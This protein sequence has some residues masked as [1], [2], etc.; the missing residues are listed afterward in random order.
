MPT[1]PMINPANPEQRNRTTVEMTVD[2][3]CV[4]LDRC[5]KVKEQSRQSERNDPTGGRHTQLKPTKRR[6][7][8]LRIPQLCRW[9]LAEHRQRR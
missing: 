1:P 7:V 6:P 5:R 8:F 9:R 4:V 3:R 2:A